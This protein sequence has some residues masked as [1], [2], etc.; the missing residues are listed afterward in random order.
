MSPKNQL[1]LAPVDIAEAAVD[2]AAVV[3]VAVADE[4]GDAAGKAAVAVD[5]AVVVD[6]TVV[7]DKVV[8]VVD[9]AAVDK[10]P[11]VVV[12]KDLAVVVGYKAVAVADRGVVAVAGKALTVVAVV[13][14]ALAVVVV[15]DKALA[16]AAADKALTVA[17]NALAVVV[18]DK[19]AVV[20]VVVDK[21]VAVVD[22]AVAVDRVLAV[23]VHKAVVVDKVAV[24]DMVAAVVDKAVAVG[25][26]GLAAVDSAVGMVAADHTERVLVGE[27]LGEEAVEGLALDHSVNKIDRHILITVTPLWKNT[28]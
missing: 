22:T 14:K 28:W 21:A 18:V 19:A 6:K 3:G 8:V 23:V 13:D 11:A 16:A 9:R 25:S 5:R 17:D 20:V 27:V 15:V 10:P 26:L 2:F 1:Y 12:C 4:T 24:D 7:V